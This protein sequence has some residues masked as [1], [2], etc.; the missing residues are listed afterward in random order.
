LPAPRP[1]KVPAGA[2][3]IHRHLS[4]PVAEL[5]SRNLEWSNNLVSELLLLSTA[6]KLSGRAENGLDS[7]ALITRWLQR[8]VPANWNGYFA[9]NGSGLSPKARMTPAQAAALVRWAD[10]RSFGGHAYLSLLPIGAW[11]GSLRD[12]F[13]DPA[14]ALRV[15]AKTGTMK[16]GSALAG[17]Y[18]SRSNRKRIFALMVSDLSRREAFD[19][20]APDIA[21][22]REWNAEGS[23]WVDRARRL[24]DELVTTW[25]LKD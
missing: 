24:Q 5:V 20:A 13:R 4:A 19:A 12:R 8:Q 21:T 16:Y 14:S 11:K 1:A 18:F 2:E 15:W 7:A 17:F 22:F 10:Q 3:T 9:E 23:D 6:R 25:I